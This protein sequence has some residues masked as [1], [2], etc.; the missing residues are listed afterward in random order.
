MLDEPV[1]VGRVYNLTLSK[2]KEKKKKRRM[3]DHDIRSIML[4]TC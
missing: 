1:F 3:N 2:K 4:F